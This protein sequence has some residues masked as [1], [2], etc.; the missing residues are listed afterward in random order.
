MKYLALCIM[1]KNE[2]EDLIENIN[3]HRLLGVQ[4]FF[5]YDNSSSI[6]IS[7]KIKNKDVTI[8][9]WEDSKKG[10]HVR[11][12]EHCLKNNK[13]WNWIG[14]IDTDEFIV[15]K[16]GCTDLKEFLI[17]YEGYGG[18]GIQWKCFGSSGHSRRPKSVINSYIHPSNTNDDK[19]I[20][21]ILQPKFAVKTNGNPHCFVYIDGKKCINENKKDVF[22]PYNWPMTRDKIQL[23]HYVVKSR[24]DFER[25]K[26]RGGG[27]IRNSNKLSESFWSR[28][29]GNGEVDKTI[30]D[31]YNKLK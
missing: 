26:R 13:D 28:F 4:H 19:H 15:L 1:S 9:R 31:L 3:Y 23:N 18:L 22:G 24:Q 14:F 27:N 25:K 11:A 2:T 7:E 6:P 21:T 29:Q 17:D 12:F 20:K 10:S 16:N 8:F 30:I 5:I